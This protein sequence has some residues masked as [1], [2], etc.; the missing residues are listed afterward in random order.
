MRLLKL[1]FKNINS[2]AGRWEIDFENPQFGE[3]LFALTG[4]TGAGKTSVL[5]AICL[6]FYGQT[7]RQE[8][9]RSINEVMTRG[10]G[11]CFAEV[12]FEV[13]GKG[14]RSS[15][16]QHR[17]RMKPNG[18]LQ[19]ATRKIASL[20]EGEII[21]EKLSDAAS[22]MIELIGMDFKQ[23]TRAVLLAQ[24]QFDAF[25]KADEK[26]RS[27]ILEQVT[28]S[29]IYSKIGTAVFARWQ[30]ERSK[31]DD[32]EKG[33]DYIK[34]LAAEERGIEQKNLEGLQEQ[35]KSLEKILT[36]LQIQTQWIEGLEKLR[37]GHRKHIDD[38][39]KLETEMS[40]AKPEFE[41][42]AKALSARKLDI[43]LHGL[44]A[45]RKSKMEAEKELNKRKI[46]SEK[47]ANEIEALKP[48]LAKAAEK[49]LTAKE[50][51]EKTLPLLHE[52][53]K[54]DSGIS[55]ANSELNSAGESAGE[56]KKLLEDANSAHGKSVK[57]LQ[58][59]EDELKIADS[60]LKSHPTDDKLRDILPSVESYLGI[61][62]NKRKETEKKALDAKKAGKN[63]ADKNEALKDAKL[64]IKKLRGDHEKK[65][66]LRET[67]EKIKLE[68][69]KIFETK[70]PDL[71]TKIRL[72]SEKLLLTQRVATL[73]E[74]R[75][76]LEDGKPCPLCGAEEHPYAKGNLPK[77]SKAQKELEG[78]KKELDE[79]QDAEK[80]ARKA[81][82]K[83][84][85]EFQKILTELQGK[86]SA[87]Q[88]AE[89]ESEKSGITART[90]MESA[91]ESAKGVKE[92]WIIITG[93]LSELEMR[94]AKPE[95]VGQELEKLKARQSEFEKQSKAAQNANSMIETG[96]EAVVTARKQID[97]SKSDYERKCEILKKKKETVELLIKNRNE[98][99]TGDT[100]ST[101]KQLRKENEEAAAL[102]SELR[103]T[104]NSLEAQSKKANE[105]LEE[106]GNILKT[107]I[108]EESLTT[109][110][111]LQKFIEAG[112]ASESECIFARWSDEDVSRVTNLH[113]ELGDKLIRIDTLI[114]KFA[115]DTRN[116]EEKALTDIPLSE[117]NLDM[118]E[119]KT[120]D[121]ALVT[122]IA[123]L[124][125]KLKSDDETRNKFADKLREMEAQRKLFDKWNRLNSWIGGANGE[126]FKRY[127][128]GITLSHLLKEANRH[129]VKM[130]AGRYEMFWKAENTSLL[131]SV[132]DRH[133]GDVER[134]VSNFSGGETFMVSL[135]LALGL[136]GLASGRLRIDSLFLDEGFGTLDNQ[137]LDT[138]V[139]TLAELHQTQGK[140]IGV[141]SHIEQM[142]SQIPTRIE[143]RKIGGGRS[144]MA[145]AG[146]RKI[147]DATDTAS[148]PRSKKRK[149]AKN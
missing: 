115:E 51:L 12:E 54:M 90:A 52:V 136:A 94:D 69:E 1:R 59:A 10:T 57:Q 18:A 133:Q 11:E 131:P 9:S 56:S 71:D 27:D 33:M 23:F 110:S 125:A 42:L 149:I 7:A 28:G 108:Q 145:G 73:E 66:M 65:K 64:A 2:L 74:H 82:E 107:K 116:E 46:A 63:A 112:F 98:K 113:K 142:K 119:Q 20:P 105:E 80:E 72:A 111:S 25:L 61:W 15:W 87:V 44:D 126:Q 29:E 137:T 38:K 70:K 53:R 14:Y 140:L 121:E 17:E 102:D 84:D 83:V 134:P 96:K 78:Y 43:V 58:K 123:E 32:L 138:A 141:I 77:L 4:P 86:E 106:A 99:F 118:A 101:E 95:T 24:G 41:R 146:V 76:S 124:Q 135:S 31:K 88:S 85:K 129:L 30:M 89:L 67:A 22:K 100:D 36:V 16:E 49:T 109:R 104:R 128:Q 39:K 117:L 48:R 75:K 34:P 91:N 92:N 26:A 120:K 139:N 148:T 35:K 114:A 6:G 55:T 132:I 8:I 93:K 37:D 21:A 40:D 103:S 68:T 50:K 97:K 144:E 45:V 130:T 19:S 147:E 127:A 60:Y 13:R 62:N 79:L 81:F 122:A 5:D 143:I 3:G 47:F